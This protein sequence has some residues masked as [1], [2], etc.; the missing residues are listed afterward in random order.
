M[1]I[2]ESNTTNF[3]N[4]FCSYLK[5]QTRVVKQQILLKITKL[6]NIK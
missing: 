3:H 5:T 4:Y 2:Y 1:A 6:K